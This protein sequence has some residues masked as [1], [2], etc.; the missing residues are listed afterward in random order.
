VSLGSGW[1][2]ELITTTRRPACGD[3]F[4]PG[5]IVTSNLSAGA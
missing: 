5:A 1:L 4:N 3:E 2:L